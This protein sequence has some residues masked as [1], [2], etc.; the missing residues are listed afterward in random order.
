VA[1]RLAKGEWC[2]LAKRREVQIG[3]KEVQTG[4]HLLSMVLPLR[5]DGSF[6]KPARLQ[7]VEAQPNDTAFKKQ[8]KK[9]LLLMIG[10]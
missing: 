5:V 10:S 4:L 3:R 7:K 9:K 2:K 1:K 6:P 8:T